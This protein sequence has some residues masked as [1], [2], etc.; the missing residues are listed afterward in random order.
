M[1]AKWKDA[2]WHQTD[3]ELVA[4]S[5]V[6]GQ[7]GNLSQRHIG[8]SYWKKRLKQRDHTHGTKENGALS[9]A[10]YFCVAQQ[11]EAGYKC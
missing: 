10:I 11:K 5:Q 4:A 2:D 7:L 6:R 9:W 3:V 1:R 8:I